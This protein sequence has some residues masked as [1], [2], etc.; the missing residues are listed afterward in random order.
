MRFQELAIRSRL[1]RY[2]LPNETRLARF[3]AILHDE[4]SVIQQSYVTENHHNI[5][6]KNNFLLVK[7][8]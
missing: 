2:R 1:P 6:V 4:H 5:F 8:P 3:V 7:C